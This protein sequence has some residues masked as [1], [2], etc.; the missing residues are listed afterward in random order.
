MRKVTW[1][2]RKKYRGAG[3]LYA[4]FSA[5]MAGSYCGLSFDTHISV[6]FFCPF[7][8]PEWLII[9]LWHQRRG[10]RSHDSVSWNEKGRLNLCHSLSR[11]PL[12]CVTHC[13]TLFCCCCEVCMCFAR[14]YKICTSRMN[15]LAPC[16]WIWNTLLINV[17]TNF[18]GGKWETLRRTE[19]RA[20]IRKIDNVLVQCKCEKVC[21]NR[22]KN[23]NP[24]HF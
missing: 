19:L 21:Q 16:H 20:G 2:D 9:L 1:I 22:A 7:A 4:L 18:I 5:W 8:L 3:G 15:A 14:H 11:N 12:A 13:F 10:K 6:I 23:P 24:L 17:A